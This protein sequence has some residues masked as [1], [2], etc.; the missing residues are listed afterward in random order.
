[1]ALLTKDTT[2][3]TTTI[4]SADQVTIAQGRL[5]TLAATIAEADADIERLVEE[6][7]SSLAAVEVG[8]TAAQARA[9]ALGAQ[10]A[11]VR[12]RRTDL[13]SIGSALRAGIGR[14][15]TNLAAAQAAAAQVEMV[16]L[17]REARQ[18]ERDYVAAMTTA[19]QAGRRLNILGP[20]MAKLR[21]VIY[22]GS[23][24]VDR[25][26]QALQPRYVNLAVLRDPVGSMQRWSTRRERRPSTA[27]RLHVGPPDVPEGS[28]MAYRYGE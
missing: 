27:P 7:G 10:L 12:D 19:G 8:N 18:L 24:E 14:Y 4:T 1:M 5:L 28:S 9:D 6:R 15:H 3:P 11:S 26:P 21:H 22:L 20:R 13:L 25:T 16:E 2:L 17:A 23:G